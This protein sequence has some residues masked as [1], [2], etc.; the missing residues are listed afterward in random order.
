MNKT[1][2]YI[3]LW[4]NKTIESDTEEINCTDKDTLG[5]VFVFRTKIA[6]RKIYGQGVTLLPIEYAKN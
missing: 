1:V 4:L 6:A 2:G 5:V 3:A